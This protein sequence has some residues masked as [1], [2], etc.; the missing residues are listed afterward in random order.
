MEPAPPPEP[1]L[2]RVLAGA[3]GIAGLALSARALLLLAICGGFALA[4]RTPDAW[5]LAMLGLYGVFV[6]APVAF[7]EWSKR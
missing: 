4:M 5:S 3:F 2:Y 1:E 6:V 7:L